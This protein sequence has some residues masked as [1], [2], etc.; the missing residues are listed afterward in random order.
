MEATENSVEMI[1]HSELLAD[2]GQ[3]K[4]SDANVT[5]QVAAI[6]NEVTNDDEHNTDKDTVDPTKQYDRAPELNVS[7]DEADE[8]QA[9]LQDMKETPIVVPSV[10]NPKQHTINGADVSKIPEHRPT[11]KRTILTPDEIER[12]LEANMEQLE[13]STGA[14]NKVVQPTGQNNSIQ[15]ED[16]IAIL[17]GDDAE[18]VD[19]EDR[20]IKEAE[21]AKKQI[22]SLPKIARGRRPKQAIS[23]SDLVQDLVDDWSDND[24]SN[25]VS[26]EVTAVESKNKQETTITVVPK[27]P[28]GGAS[29]RKPSQSTLVDT[30]PD[31]GRTMVEIIQT[32]AIEEPQSKVPVKYERKRVI[33]KKI[34]WD[35][36]DPSPVYGGGR[37]TGGPVKKPSPSVAKPKVD[38]EISESE[39][40]A[41]QLA[42]VQKPKP[43]EAVPKGRAA[44]KKRRLNEIDKLLAD[45]GA[46]NMIYDLER[47]NDG[48]NI[49][50]IQK[51][52]EEEDGYQVVD[53]DEE[54]TNLAKKAKLLKNAVIKQT[55]SPP[56]AP[57]PRAA[58][59][60]RD[61]TPTSTPSPVPS[62]SSVS[63]G[64]KPA[65]AAAVKTSKSASSAPQP[66]A[67][68]LSGP[69]AAKKRKA[70]ENEQ[71]LI[72]RRRSTSSFSDPGS[73]RRMSL[74]DAEDEPN[75]TNGSTAAADSSTA[76]TASPQKPTTTTAATTSVAK[77]ET[78]TAADFAKPKP[79]RR[80]R[81]KPMD[82]SI[83]VAQIKGKLYAKPPVKL[84]VAPKPVQRSPVSM[85]AASSS[86]EPMIRSPEKKKMLDSKQLSIRKYDKFAFVIMPS[87]DGK[88]K[89]CLTLQLVN[90][91]I[92][93]LRQLEND[94]TCNTVVLTSA[95]TNF[96]NGINYHLLIQADE[97]K[98]KSAAREFANAIRWVKFSFYLLDAHLRVPIFVK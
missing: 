75:D 42:Q 16:L 78:K 2:L 26:Y 30:D 33:K 22:A 49:P 25:G 57:P 72:I 7:I 95:G 92:A 62:A 83:L 86:P 58:R 4:S 66:V 38:E 46:I 1:D 51:A 13:P 71:S 14:T 32:P 19:Q 98:R 8:V 21:I 65:S 53:V 29:K 12:E 89:D 91:I 67:K 73:P 5:S 52:V 40:P 77:K 17:E 45:E 27:K 94:A 97:E 28:A 90:K 24:E 23:A 61:L 74:D 63:P 6:V 64:L 93:A 59:A 36:D 41:T 48:S 79:S 96:C 20:R 76:S 10:P 39:S 50:E 85:P 3:E 88:L 44:G 9:A 47:E 80:P 43:I 31:S 18:K 35:P 87:I 55:T 54:K 56:A 68:K 11:R 70:L 15:S 34:I 69:A 82:T 84:P 60:K 81:S 37:A